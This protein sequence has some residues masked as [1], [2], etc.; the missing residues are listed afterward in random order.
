MVIRPRD[1]EYAFQAWET[2]SFPRRR[3][4]GFI[5]RRVN[6]EGKYTRFIDPEGYSMVLTKAAFIQVD[7]MDLWWAETTEMREFREYV[8][9]REL[10]DPLYPYYYTADGT[11]GNLPEQYPSPK[12][13]CEDIAMSYLYAHHTR[14]PPLWIAGA[15]F[16]DVGQ[17]NKDGISSHKG[18]NAARQA[19]V[20]HFDEAFGGD[21]LVETQMQ[22]SLMPGRESGRV[23]RLWYYAR[24]WID[25]VA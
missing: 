6:E 3:M 17:A 24:S 10:A 11:P 9:A 5:R 16:P 19:C 20:R 13:G 2:Y 15:T 25:S 23:W 22:V 14:E 7:W 21:T 4:A 12:T 1:V 18:H 8:D